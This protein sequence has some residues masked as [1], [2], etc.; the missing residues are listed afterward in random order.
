MLGLMI[1]SVV[2]LAAFLVVESRVKEP[3]C[4][5]ICSRSGYYGIDGSQY[6]GK[7]AYYRADHVFATVDS[8]GSGRQRDLVGLTLAPMSI[9]WLIG[10]II[11]GRL[12]IKSG[13]RK[14]AIIGV[15]FLIIGAVGL[16]FM[17]KDTA[18]GV[19]WS[20]RSFMGSA[21]D[22]SPP[23]FRSSRNPRWVMRSGELPRR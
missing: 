20:L 15:V 6:S 3:I 17:H 9:G 14:T 22:I 4:R 13:S 23:C 1:G 18:L 8:R 10:S 12:I 2:L 5:S 11:S 7:R 16:A 21:L 19:C